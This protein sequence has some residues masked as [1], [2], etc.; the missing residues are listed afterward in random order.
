M[1]K[2]DFVFYEVDNT[3]GHTDYWFIVEGETQKQLTEKYNEMCMVGVREV[4]YSQDE[5]IVGIKRQ[6]HWN[7]DVVISDDES[8][9][10]T[11][12]SIIKEMN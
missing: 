5:D 9:K 1:R 8:L 11:L 12:K 7:Y 2:E 6:F 3:N 10:E 4:V